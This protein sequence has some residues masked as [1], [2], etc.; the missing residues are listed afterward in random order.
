[1]ENKIDHRSD[2]N[3]GLVWG[4]ILI[5]AGLFFLFGQFVP[6]VIGQYGW[7]FA[8][9]AAG[10]VFLVV[11]VTFKGVHG[12]VVPGT[13]ITVVAMILAVQ[14]T[15]DAWATWA[16]AWALVVPGSA[17]LGA[18]LLGALNHDHRQVD[19]GIRGA[20]VGLALFA[21][22]GMFFEGVLHISGFNFGVAADVAFPLVLVAAGVI[23]LAFRLAR[24]PSS[25]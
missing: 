19:D 1:M 21:L 9:L 23:L 5:I 2:R 15:F 17:G 11:G 25:Q 20:F 7:P 18:A 6:D 4:L 12:L 24:R 3:A 10:L 14:N 22:F 8:V 13:M 16:Y